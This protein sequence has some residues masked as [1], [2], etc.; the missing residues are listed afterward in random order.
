MRFR[1]KHST[2]HRGFSP[3]SYPKRD[4]TLPPKKPNPIGGRFYSQ[5]T[6]PSLWSDAVK[7]LVEL[8]N[9]LIG[10]YGTH[11]QKGFEIGLQP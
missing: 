3:P 6:G 10:K 7:E 9:D 8:S 2:L 1:V 5:V 11:H 4:R